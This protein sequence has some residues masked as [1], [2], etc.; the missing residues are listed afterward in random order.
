MTNNV[1]FNGPRAGI[2]FNDGFGGHSNITENLIFNQCRE[3]GDHGAMNSWDRTAYIS[4]VKYGRPSYTAAMNQVANN[5][6]IAN[7]GAS[8]GFDTDD[9]SSWYD[10]HDNF[11]FMADAWKMDYGGHDSKFMNNVIYHGHNDG[12]VHSYTQ[13]KDPSHTCFGLLKYFLRML[14]TRQS[15]VFVLQN[16]VNIWPFLPTH[17]APWSG[18]KCILP[19]VSVLLMLLA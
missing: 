2:N 9:G 1:F 8:Q 5:F 4:D 14:L 19:K 13:R 6:I 10:I 18:N 15:I 3:S 16:C 11:F 17:G 7:Y 12:Q